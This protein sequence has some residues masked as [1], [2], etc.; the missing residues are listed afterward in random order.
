MLDINI[1][2]VSAQEFEFSKKRQ[3]E[4]EKAGLFNDHEDEITYDNCEP[5]DE[6]FD[7][8]KRGFRNRMK[9][10]FY[11][12]ALK[13]YN[14]RINR[15]LTNLK[16]VGRENLAGVKGGRIVTCN[17]ISKVDSF[18]V[19][20]AIGPEFK[21]V[22]ADFNNWKGILGDLSRNTGYLPLPAKMNFALMRKF[23][24]AIE[25]FLQKKWP[26]LFYPEQALWCEYKKPRPLKRG[27]FF[28]AA[29][30]HCPI[31]PTFITLQEKPESVD[32]Q[33][34]VNYCDY[35]IHIL[36]PIYPRADLD[37]RDNIEYMMDANFQAWRT[38]YEK[39]YGKPLVYDTKLTKDTDAVVRK[40]VEMVNQPSK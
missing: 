33:G 29:K 35:T 6:S 27:A 30:H 38:C 17:H 9:H 13:I 32:T 26:I 23:N 39:V 40:Y 15:Q 10:W 34:R 24:Q 16:V 1:L 18:A 31:I 37:E 8:L 11:M 36:P 4:L 2:K 7:Y 20:A 21:F 5:V 3:Q 12:R 14:K 25:Y 22:A 19:R 28:Y